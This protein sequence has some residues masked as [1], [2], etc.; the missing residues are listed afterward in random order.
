MR[1]AFITERY[2]FGYFPVT[3]SLTS[4]ALVLKE[5]S[6]SL[7][8]L[9]TQQLRCRHRQCAKHECFKLL[10][11]C[12]LSGRTEAS[13]LEHPTRSRFIVAARL[14]GIRFLLLRLFGLFVF[15]LV[16]V[17]IPALGLLLFYPWPSLG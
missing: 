6:A 1:P 2:P 16:V 11:S 7:G 8:P 3:A 17:R 13:K 4:Q 9:V 10:E 12:E 14:L 15:T 5:F